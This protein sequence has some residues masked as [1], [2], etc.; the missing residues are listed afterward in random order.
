MEHSKEFY[1]GAIRVIDFLKDGDGTLP[2]DKGYELADNYWPAIVTLLKDYQAV[3]VLMG[4]HIL[5][6]RGQYLD[7][8]YKDCKHKIAAIDKAENDRI[9]DLKYKIKGII[10]GR[11]SLIVSILA[12]LLS[13]WTAVRQAGIL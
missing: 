7:P 11:I 12:F 6:T 4:G 13:I 8:L 5:V 1:E 2:C 10:Y 9:V 3:N